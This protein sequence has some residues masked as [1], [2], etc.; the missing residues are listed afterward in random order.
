[1]VRGSRSTC[2]NKQCFCVF[3]KKR[4]SIVLL[5]QPSMKKLGLFLS[6]SY[7]QRK[8]YTEK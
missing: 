7:R 8:R 2:W 5:S 4:A 3:A 1:M 6:L